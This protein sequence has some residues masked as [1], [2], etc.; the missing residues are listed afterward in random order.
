MIATVFDPPYFA[1]GQMGRWQTPQAADG[2]V[3][4]QRPLHHDTCGVA[5]PLPICADAKMGRIS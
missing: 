1:A 5:V 4:A 2:G 3:A